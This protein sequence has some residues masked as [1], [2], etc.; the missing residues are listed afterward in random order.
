MAKHFAETG[1]TNFTLFGGATIYAVT[2]HVQRLAGMLA[3]FC[4]DETTSYDGVKTR[5]ELAAK[6]A[7][8]GVDPAKFT[9]SK[10]TISGYMQ[11]FSFDDAFSTQLT[12]SMMAG[13]TTV[14]SVGAGDAVTGI[15]FG[16]AQ[17]IDAID[18]SKL[19][20]GGV[21]SI[22]TGYVNFFDMGYSYDCGKFASIMAPG[23]VLMLK[24]CKGEVLKDANGVVPYL[25]TSYWVATSK[26]EIE[27][28]LAQDNATDGF[29]YNA[30]VVQHF[31]D[32]DYSEF[33]KLCEADFQA[34]MQIKDQYGK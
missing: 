14:L 34:A 8:A 25:G 6:V 21:D 3:Y 15:A 32:A 16:I 19:R 5:N 26:A 28:M 24:A 33:K 31:V 18:A 29:C 27:E 12:N 30:K 1:S 7:G 10:Y 23:L 13:G 9:S 17:A 20:T 22:A 11:G 4:E 2:M